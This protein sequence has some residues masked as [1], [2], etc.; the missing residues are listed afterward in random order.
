VTFNS[1][2]ANPNSKTL[3]SGTSGSVVCISVSLTSLT[4]CRGKSSNLGRFPNKG[5]CNISYQEVLRTLLKNANDQ[6]H[7]ALLCNQ[8]INGQLLRT[9]VLTLFW[10]SAK[11]CLS[12]NCDLLAG[13]GKI[14]L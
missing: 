14:F 12:L 2:I 7:E 3:G 6:A 5:R 10:C 13:E 4:P 11:F 9:S 8:S 1:S